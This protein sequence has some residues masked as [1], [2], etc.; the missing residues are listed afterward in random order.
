MLEVSPVA[1]ALARRILLHEAGGRA[2][3]V[4][5]A[6]AAARADARLHARLA[7]LIGTTGYTTLVA[8][9]VRL[10]QA[11]VPALEHVPVDTGAGAEGSL[12]E[13]RA[14]ALASG[15]PGA[16]ESG[17]SA[18]LAH[19]IGLLIT[20][21]GEDQALRLIRETWPE[22]AHGPDESEGQA[23]AKARA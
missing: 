15:N 11:E 18:I 9:A 1:H 16:T 21:I 7:D 14:F 8:R 10:A 23:G 20:F 6:E 3:P 2:E 13:V 17:L 4:A 19:V 22:L 12:R 5:R